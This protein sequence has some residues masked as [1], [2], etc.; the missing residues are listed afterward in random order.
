MACRLTGNCPDSV[1]RGTIR[2]GRV[3]SMNVPSRDSL[4]DIEWLIH[5]HETEGYEA[6]LRAVTAGA[7]A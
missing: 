6:L 3:Y 7:E 5:T 4:L 2:R 1:E